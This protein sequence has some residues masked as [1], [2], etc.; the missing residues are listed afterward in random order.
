MYKHLII[1]SL[2]R[3]LEPL[4]IIVFPRVNFESRWFRQKYK[5]YI[6]CLR[7]IWQRNILRLA[8]PMP[9]PCSLT[10][11]VSNPDKISFHSDDL[12]NFQSPGCYFQCFMG[13]ISL[14]RGCYIAPNVGIITINHDPEDLDCHEEPKDVSIGNSV[15]IG[16]NAVILPGVYLANNIIVGAGAVVTKSCFDPGQ[17][18]LG[19]PAIP[20]QTNDK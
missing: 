6:W 12:N 10:C 1:K 16:M 18:L 13:N 4:F 7:A 5:G 9:W 8:P 17:V 15:W 2:F 20:K 11:F 3:V 14:G 19:I